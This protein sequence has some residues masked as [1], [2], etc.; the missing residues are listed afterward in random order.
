[1]TAPW[2]VEWTTRDGRVLRIGD[3]DRSHRENTMAW[4]LRTAK[5]HHARAVLRLQFM[6][7]GDCSIHV[8]DGFDREFDDLLRR[9]PVEW[10]REQPIFQA[11]AALTPPGPGTSPR[12]WQNRRAALRAAN[13]ASF[14]QWLEEVQAA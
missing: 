8:Q 6:V 12:R 13:P 9:D 5:H 7:P 10:M 1:M 2:N 3:M 11:L 4:L 14:L